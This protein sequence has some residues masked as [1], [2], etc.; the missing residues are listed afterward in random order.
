MQRFEAKLSRKVGICDQRRQKSAALGEPPT[1]PLI[2]CFVRGITWLFTLLN[3]SADD[4]LQN[5]FSRCWGQSI[6][7]TVMMLDKG[8]NF[9]VIFC[10]VEHLYRLSLH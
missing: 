7:K 2:P 6:A 10:H 5:P 9:L 4:L 1:L 8:S 3:G